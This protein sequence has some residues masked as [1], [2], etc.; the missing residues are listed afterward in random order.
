MFL[1]CGHQFYRS[2]LQ[3]LKQVQADELVQNDEPA[4]F[5]RTTSTTSTTSTGFHV[6]QR[7]FTILI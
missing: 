6:H 3:I 4:G 5:E 2:F 1:D 7:N